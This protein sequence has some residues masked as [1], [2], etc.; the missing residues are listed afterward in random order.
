MVLEKWPILMSV[1]CHKYRPT[2]QV[3]VIGHCYKPMSQAVEIGCCTNERVESD[4]THFCGKV[5]D[6]TGFFSAFVV[7]QTKKPV[8]SFTDSFFGFNTNVFIN[9][10]IT[11][12]IF[13]MKTNASNLY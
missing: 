13:T 6:I 2:L 9:I 3:V 11:L 7:M 5:L 8:I 1:I 12:Y 4:L 10:T